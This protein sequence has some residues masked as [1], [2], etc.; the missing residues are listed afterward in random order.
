MKLFNH[1]ESVILNRDFKNLQSKAKISL[2]DCIS[3]AKKFPFCHRTDKDKAGSIVSKGLLS[4]KDLKEVKGNTWYLDKLFK[5]D[6][7]IFFSY[8]PSN[9]VLGDIIFIMTYDT[10]K[11]LNC[12]IQAKDLADIWDI[13]MGMLYKGS[14]FQGISKENAQLKNLKKLKSSMDRKTFSLEEFYRIIG[15]LMLRFAVQKNISNTTELARRFFNYKKFIGTQIELQINERIDIS[16][17]D[18]VYSS[19]KFEWPKSLK[20]RVINFFPNGENI[21][22]VLKL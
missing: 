18:Y 21:D 11:N 7:K 6:E 13:D 19:T 2:E 12:K 1:I 22:K 10:V 20:S 8:G 5:K 3:L 4:H 16:D 14:V 9:I 15:T 17:I